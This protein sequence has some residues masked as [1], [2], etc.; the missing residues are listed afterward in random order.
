MRGGREILKMKYLFFLTIIFISCNSYYA[1][2]SAEKKDSLQPVFTEKP[3][4]TL[5]GDGDLKL[6]N[7]FSKHLKEDTANVQEI[8]SSCAIII[9][10]TQEQIAEDKKIDSNSFYI[11][12]DDNSW[13]MAQSTETLDTF[14]IKRILAIKRFLKLIGK[15]SVWELDI[16]KKYSP[17]WNLILFNRNK[18]P[19]IVSTPDVNG[20]TIKKY[21]DLH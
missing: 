12:A 15:D 1:P 14:K 7:Y 19:E 5:T 16:R 17:E 11:V 21:F 6:E 2:H 13:Y 4:D 9:F 8:D 3:F 10:P 18:K 20:D